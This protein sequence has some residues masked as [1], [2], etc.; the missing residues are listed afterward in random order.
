MGVTVAAGCDS[1]VFI[2]TD[3]N[4][5]PQPSGKN[6]PRPNPTRVVR[7]EESPYGRVPTPLP[8]VTR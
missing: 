4:L 2:I 5:T 3:M 1:G 7:N 8:G 6:L